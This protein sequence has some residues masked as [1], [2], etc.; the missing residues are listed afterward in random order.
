MFCHFDFKQVSL[1]T[2]E[3]GSP[4]PTLNYSVLV[5]PSFASLRNPFSEKKWRKFQISRIFAST[6]AA[7]K[8]QAIDV[9]VIESGCSYIDKW[10]VS[11]CLGSGQTRNMALDRYASN[12]PDQSLKFR[13][14]LPSKSHL[15]YLLSTSK[16]FVKLAC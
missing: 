9:H 13:V 10:F 2:W 15:L 11:L 6:S 4:Q 16:K 7:I 8:M 12:N 1:S 3:V 5:D 14:F